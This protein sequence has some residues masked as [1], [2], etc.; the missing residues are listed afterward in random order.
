MTVVINAKKIDRFLSIFAGSLSLLA[1]VFTIIAIR[2]SS[3][4]IN[5]Y[6]PDGEVEWSGLFYQCTRLRCMLYYNT[7][8]V[9]II[10]IIF[11]GL[12]LLVSTVSIFLL[13][14]HSFPRRH[15]YLTP[16]F[17]FIGL[18]CLL[19]SLCFY[20][21]RSLVNGISARLVITAIV[22]TLIS[23]TIAT[24]LA[25]NHAVL[26]R[27]SVQNYK[28]T[29]TETDEPP[30]QVVNEGNQTSTENN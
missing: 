28:Y 1:L 5:E 8:F 7:N 11:G 20:A 21:H 3:W 16:I 30:I 6:S 24:Y 19:F 22:L 13:I 14:T 26:Y 9:S 18:L 4:T 27:Q 25:G 17:V 29:K 12:F 15:F 10:T 2:T 23:F